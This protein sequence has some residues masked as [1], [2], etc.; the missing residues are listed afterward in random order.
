MSRPLLLALLII[1]LFSI[2]QQTDTTQEESFRPVFFG[3]PNQPEV[4]RKL[5]RSAT[6]A[7]LDVNFLRPV[8]S[9]K[10]TVYDKVGLMWDL[11]YTV[12]FYSGNQR[13]GLNNASSGAFRF[14]GY[15]DLVRRKPGNI[16]G[17][18][19]KIEH[20][21]KYSSIPPSDL[22]DS[23]GYVGVINPDLDNSKFRLQNFYWRQR[24]LKSRLFFTI[25]FLDAPDFI[26]PYYFPDPFTHFSNDHFGA[27][28]SAITIPNGGYLGISASFWTTK[29]LYLSA[30]FGDLNANPKNAFKGFKSFF[31][32]HQYFKYIEIGA[33]SSKKFLYQENAH[34]TFWHAD[35]SDYLLTPAGW[36]LVASLSTLLR[37]KWAPFLRGAY[38]N[39]AGTLLSGSVSMGFGYRHTDGG[40]LLGLAG[41]WGRPNPH[42]YQN[43]VIVH[44]NQYLIEA[45]YRIQITG[46]LAFTPD[47][48]LIFN[49]ALNQNQDFIFVGGMR[50][51]IAL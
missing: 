19:Y 4:R 30:G 25:G 47:F 22:A 14:Y 42:T 17:M 6:E 38:S 23:V 9:I 33:S 39:K 16:G 31:Q 40:H 3:G 27:G 28:A 10:D 51:R 26:D 5:D 18:V 7:I 21:H 13:I 2:G 45:F 37:N 24:L 36:G 44:R 8:S 50:L 32:Q 46:K 1:P 34:I 48:Q 43:E 12:G 49:P 11:D 35:K 41:A 29:W 20:R 15:W